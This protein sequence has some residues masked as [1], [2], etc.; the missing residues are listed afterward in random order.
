MTKHLIA[1]AFCLLATILVNPPHTQ[2]QASAP[3]DDAAIGISTL[4]LWPSGDPEIAG[5][6]P[7]D[8]PTLTVFVPQH[9]NGTGSAVI[10]APGGSYLG[11]ASNLRIM[12]R[13]VADQPSRQHEDATPHRDAGRRRRQRG[14]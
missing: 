11:L 14:Q 12:H 6:A 10:I 1:S 5:T 7:A 2:A 8:L 13:H 3:V 9:G 4:R